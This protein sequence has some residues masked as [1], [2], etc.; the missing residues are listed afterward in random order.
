MTNETETSTPV[1]T[2]LYI[3]GTERQAASTLEIVDPGKP[4][5]TVGHAAAAA[6]ATSRTQLRRRRPLTRDGLR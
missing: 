6:P 3:G 5:V 1:T 2:G 4:G